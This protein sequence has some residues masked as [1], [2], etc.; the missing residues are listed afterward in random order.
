M[1]EGDGR[2]WGTRIRDVGEAFLGVVRAEIAALASDLGQSGRALVRA[3]VWVGAAAAVLFWTLG[4]LI[5]AA[6]ELLALVLPR[7]G[8]AS[9]VFGVFAITAFSL[10]AL[11]RARL[12]AIEPPDATVR[13]RMEESRRWWNERVAAEEP[14]EVAAPQRSAPLPEGARPP[15]APAS[16]QEEE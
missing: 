3:L 12:A 14:G 5:Y 2:G 8:A 9:V 4:L 1:R 10:V 7:W 6:V 16:R 11:A 13:R 15:A